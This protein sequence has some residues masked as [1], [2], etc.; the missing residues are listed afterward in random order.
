[1]INKVLKSYL[2][3]LQQRIFVL[4]LLTTLFSVSAL[5]QNQIIKLRKGAVPIV[6][7]IQEIEKQTCFSVDYGRNTLD[8]RSVVLIKKKK[9]MLYE[10]L[11]KMLANT[12]LKYKF[13]DR[14]ILIS[15]AEKVTTRVHNDVQPVAIRKISGQ[16]VDDKGEPLIGVNVIISGTHSGVVTDVSGR[17][18]ISASEGSKLQFSY[19]GMVTQTL[20]LGKALNIKVVMKEDNSVINEVVITGM[21]KVD[22]RLFTG[23]TTK[24]YADNIRINGLN[25]ISRSLEGRVAGMSVQNIT[26]TFGTAPKIRIRG[27]SSI[28]GNSKPL[29]VVDGVIM[30]DITELSTD[31][32]ST[33]DAITLISSAIAGL[34]ADDIESFQVLKDGAA[35]SIY[36]ARAMPGVI[37]VTTKKG[38]EGHPCLSYTGEFTSRLIPSYSNFNIMSSGEQ[39]VVYN[40][41]YQKGWLNYADSFH[42]QDKGIYGKMYELMNTFDEES[43][44][45][46]LE[47][48]TTAINKYLRQAESRN[49]NWFSKLFSTSI[50]QNHSV[51][52]SM[53]SD[54]A[55]FYGSLGV[56]TDPGWYKDS[57]VNRY[58][59]NMN[60]SY[61]ISKRLSFNFI[62]STSYRKQK[63]PGTLSRTIDPLY[64]DVKRDFEIN[65]YSYALNS[66]RALDPDEFYT[67]N[68]ARFNISHELDN[69][70]LDFDMVDLKLQGELKYKPF[71]DL[72][73]DLLA[74]TKYANTTQEHYI[75]DESN[76]ALAY[77]AMTDATI[78]DNNP[79]L[80][81]DPDVPYSLPISVLPEGGIYQKTDYRMNGYDFRASAS[82]NHIFNGTHIFNL[83]GG[84]ELN[85]VNRTHTYFNGWGMQ[86]SLGETPFYV[87]Q[88][89]KKSIE[90]VS[91]YYSLS[92]TRLRSLAFFA[93]LTYSYKGRYTI[94]TTYRHEGTNRLGKSNKARWLPTWNISGAWNIH[95]EPFFESLKSLLSHLSLKASY[96]LTADPGPSSITNSTILF[97]NYKPYRPSADLQESGLGIV[98]LANDELT[99]EKKHELNIGTDI[100]LLGNRINITAD[101]Y[102]RHNYDLIGVAQ[103]EGA[104]GK[105]RKLAN[106][107][108]MNSHGLE[109]AV[110]SK[111]IDR[112][113]FSWNTDFVFSTMKSKVTR[114]SPSAEAMNMVSGSGFTTEGYPVR[115]LFSFQYAGL[116]SDGLPIIVNQDGATTSQ[117]S[118]INFQSQDFS[119]LVY[120]GSTDPTMIGSLGNGFRYKGFHLNVY[121]TYSMG[122]KLRLDP[123]FS[124]IYS[125]LTAMPKE[126]KDR[127]VV[128][129]DEKTTYIPTIATRYQYDKDS[130]LKSLYNA[131][132]YSTVRVAKGDFVRMK[133][134]SIAYEFPARWIKPWGI[135][136]LSLKLQATNLFLIYADSKL[137]GQDP[138]FFRSGGVAAPVPKQFTLTLNLRI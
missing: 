58:T 97:N 119:K 68:Y 95:E 9:C 87:Y 138:E 85:A 121:I 31:Q 63:A 69:N 6:T 117:G 116:N 102:T 120:E 104:G 25:D 96:S 20:R 77:R 89:F 76:Q 101:W 1:M 53:G 113:D 94:N 61:I 122:N 46:L 28:Y 103:T 13:V 29:W 109:I 11:D 67:R 90:E 14:H 84:M 56:M 70:Y 129:G 38:V 18:S 8:L 74:A 40:E 92:K 115:S 110:S 2:L 34:N 125:D 52:I 134:I 88:F 112:T 36:G 45:F 21:S 47:N 22:K 81:T 12:D 51:S 131:Y 86:Y 54:R 80:Y 71:N 41:M 100:G 4:L 123:I 35:T 127:W 39:M 137:N 57:K 43:Q 49:T 32:L 106:I 105:I 37:V 75:K 133:E 59:A 65:P 79:W 55:S 30:D 10:L 26:G 66:S 27:A 33:G 126:F 135:S 73:I 108:D 128:K 99:Y 91:D 60:A 23:A 15:K 124:S 44:S 83:F 42:A 62:S 132:N 72:E 130:Y 48:S 17:F 82:W 78:R 98:D 3:A 16:V 24:L 7:V 107:A 136:V 93:N 118:Q 19:V 50:M 111:N 64:G 5:S 114:L